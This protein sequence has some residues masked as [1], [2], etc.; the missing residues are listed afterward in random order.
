[1]AYNLSLA[2]FWDQCAYKV[3][4][5]ERDQFWASIPTFELAPIHRQRDDPEWWDCQRFWTI[6]FMPVLYGIVSMLPDVVMPLAGLSDS[7]KPVGGSY[8]TRTLNSQPTPMAIVQ[9]TRIG[10][11]DQLSQET[12]QFRVPSIPTS[13]PTIL[14][15]SY[16]EI[17]SKA[18]ITFDDVSITA[19]KPAVQQ[20]IIQ[21]GTITLTAGGPAYTTNGHIISVASSN[22][23]VDG[24]ITASFR[25]GSTRPLGSAITLGQRTA[26]AQQIS[27]GTIRIGSAILSIGGP[28]YT[29]AGHTISLA[30]NGLVEDATATVPLSG[31]EETPRSTDS[32]H[33]IESFEPKSEKANATGQKSLG[34]P[35]FVWQIPWFLAC[36]LVFI[37][38]VL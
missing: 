13:L 29:T 1:M 22:L 18:T 36:G 16:P 11:N 24:T 38:L 3:K 14:T 26:T 8:T 28:A 27:P 31:D 37:I 10:V 32:N 12:H 5:V 21:I 6:P 19:L 7:P 20:N 17:P 30:A 34:I 25:S 15:D 9:K 4:D 33:I 35:A 23:I 2:M